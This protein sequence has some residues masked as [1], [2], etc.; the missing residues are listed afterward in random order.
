MISKTLH[1]VITAM[2]LMLGGLLNAQG[3]PVIDNASMAKS[4]LQHA[5]SLAKYLEQINTLKAQLQR[6]E[7]QF[8]SMTGTRNLGNILNDPSIRAALPED[9][10][11]VLRGSSAG[12][13]SLEN[14]IEQIKRDEQLTGDYKVDGPALEQ[15]IEWLS[16]R[17]NALLDEVQSSTQRRMHQLDQLQDQ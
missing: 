3:I 11:A 12:N 8:E 14:R 5:E 10:R 7:R 15:R 17:S 6:A 4:A 2:L 9:V 16:L 13:D 1:A